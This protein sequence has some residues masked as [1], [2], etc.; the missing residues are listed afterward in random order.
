[1]TTPNLKVVAGKDVELPTTPLAGA[2]FMSRRGFHVFR[3]VPN[4]K[5]PYRAGINEATTDEATIR[6][7]FTENPRLNY[8]VRA[9][10]GGIGIVLDHDAKFGEHWQDEAQQLFGEQWVRTFAVRT[11]T[12]G[13][14]LYFA[15]EPGGQAKLASTIDVRSANGYVLGPGSVI[16]GRLYQIIH[17]APLAQLPAVVRQKLGKRLAAPNDPAET[18]EPVVELDRLDTLERV[19]DWLKAMPG[20][21]EPGRNTRLYQ[22]ALDLKHLGVSQERAAALLDEHWVWKCTGT[23]EFTD[24]EIAKSIWSAYARNDGRAPGCLHPEADFEPLETASVTMASG[25]YFP[26][27]TRDPAKIPPRPWLFKGDMLKRAVHVLVAAPGVGKSAFSIA[28]AVAAA[29]GNADFLRM[30]FV[31]EP[32]RTLIINSED[33]ADERERRIAALCKLH[34]FE[35]A[36]LN[37]WI[38]F[39]DRADGAQ[40]VA[41]T[42]DPQN[43]NA[44]KKSEALAKLKAFI[45]QHHI[46]QVILDPFRSLHHGNENDSGDVDFVAG[47]LLEVMQSTGAAGLIIHHT[48]KSIYSSAE[49]GEADSG[50][51]SGALTGRARKTFTLNR[52]SAANAEEFGVDDGDRF[53]FIRLDD[54]KLNQS[55]KAQEPRWYELVGE[56]VGNDETAVAVRLADLKRTGVVP[57]EGAGKRALRAALQAA[58]DAGKGVPNPVLP[59][60]LAAPRDTLEQA[61]VAT[62]LQLMAE[63]G[64]K[65]PAEAAIQRAWRRSCEKERLPV[66]IERG[67]IDGVDCIYSRPMVPGE[68]FKSDPD[69]DFEP[70]EALDD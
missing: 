23:S 15:G 20:A 66:G 63:V 13:V 50:R 25:F 31:G 26:D 14:H 69:D 4:G 22:L 18:L 59:S 45:E 6:Q 7:W 38:A 64:K 54:G 47:A 58:V 40:F 65:K 62:Y 30:K 39:Y 34:G 9:D 19:T 2:L 42:R 53:R 27:L 3:V 17:D 37:G 57:Q 56:D 43:K 12:G 16:N 67:V 51:G 33:D 29:R 70:T 48:R 28:L 60:G 24:D 10:R 46:A 21:V 8:A 1:M 49:Y 5:A 41:V 32:V 35:Q 61:F 55:G 36:A 11:P 44:L 52:L 68:H